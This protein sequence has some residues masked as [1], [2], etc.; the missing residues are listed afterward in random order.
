[1]GAAVTLVDISTAALKRA[2][3]LV[4]SEPGKVVAI[5]SDANPLP[6]PSGFATKVISTEVL[7][8]VDDPKAFMAELVRIGRPGCF[9]LLSAPDAAGEEIQKHVAP[10]FYF[11]KPNHVRIFQ[12]DEFA[13]LI[14]EAGLV[15]DQRSYYGF[16]WTMYW[17]MFWP[18][19]VKGQAPRHPVLDNWVQTWNAVLAIPQGHKIQ[20]LLN[21]ILPKN[22]VIICRKPASDEKS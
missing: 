1:M 2:E 4:R 10:D 21:Q 20:Q 18:L 6:L 19:G 5:E 12:R 3:A 9:Y 14:E 8:H 15:I 7:E 16:F 13:K 22:Q 11:K 17:S